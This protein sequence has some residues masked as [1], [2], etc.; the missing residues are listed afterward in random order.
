MDG[1]R[2]SGMEGVMDGGKEGG[3]KCDYSREQVGGE[4]QA[5]SGGEEDKGEGKGREEDGWME[6]VD[7]Q[8]IHRRI[9]REGEEGRGEGG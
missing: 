5:Q 3:A 8:M 7:E 1:A 2:V 4:E 9:N 6:W